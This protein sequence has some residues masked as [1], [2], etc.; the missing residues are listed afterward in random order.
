MVVAFDPDFGSFQLW[1]RSGG[2]WSSLQ[3]VDPI[4]AP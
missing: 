4:E 1:S 3:L 2:R